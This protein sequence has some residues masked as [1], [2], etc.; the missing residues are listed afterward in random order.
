MRISIKSTC[1]Q[2]LFISYILLNEKYV[3]LKKT[4]AQDIVA[5]WQQLFS[6][7]KNIEFYMEGIGRKQN[8]NAK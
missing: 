8:S 5:L 4:Y 6:K 1:Q 3:S 7:K 2:A